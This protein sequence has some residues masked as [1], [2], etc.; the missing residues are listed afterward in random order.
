[1]D[2]RTANEVLTTASTELGLGSKSVA[3]TDA[4][5]VQLL[6][7]LNKAG[8][9]LAKLDWSF[10]KLQYTFV[11]TATGPYTLPVDFQS[12]VNGTIWDR[13]AHLPLVGPVSDQ[14]WEAMV[15]RGITNAVGIPFRIWRNALYLYPP[16]GF[17]TG[18]TIAFEY[19]SS[20]WAIAF[21][22]DPSSTT[23]SL[24]LVS[25]VADRPLF[26]FSLLVAAT[27]VE[28]KR[29]KGLDRSSEEEDFQAA[30]DMAMSDDSPGAVLNASQ[31]TSTIQMLGL[32]NLPDTGYGS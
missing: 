17:P 4:V 5:S 3:G 22:D 29:F 14:Q 6:A 18:K 15:A 25:D 1:M 10:L 28:W 8:R 30:L 11:P 13:T 19:R 16:T 2:I 9:E 12:L 21:D 7:A 24:N 27:K 32:G 31:S 20:Y 23:P 26:D